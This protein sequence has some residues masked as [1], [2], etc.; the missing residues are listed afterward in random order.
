LTKD[1]YTFSRSNISWS[2]KFSN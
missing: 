2:N 1:F